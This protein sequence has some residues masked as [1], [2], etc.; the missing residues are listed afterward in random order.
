MQLSSA[1]IIQ[2][3][4]PPVLWLSL[5][6]RRSRHALHTR[7]PNHGQRESNCAALFSNQRGCQKALEG[8]KVS[9]KADTEPQPASSSI[10]AS[11]CFNLHTIIV[12][13]A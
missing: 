1:I 5:A 11:V 9:W 4:K 10:Q 3:M 6:Q 12:P 8:I 13:H 7:H 2:L